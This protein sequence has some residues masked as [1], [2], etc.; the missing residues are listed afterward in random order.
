M[1]DIELIQ[2]EEKVVPFT[3][4]DD[5]DLSSATMSL[6]VKRDLDDASAVIEKDDDDFDK[7]EGADSIVYVDFTSDDTDQTPGIYICQIVAEDD[8]GG[9]QSAFGKLA[10]LR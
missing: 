9:K 10:V 8:S 7:S 1:A 3:Y 6:A 4:S 5:T 2:G